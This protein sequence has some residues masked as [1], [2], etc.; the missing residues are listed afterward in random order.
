V[1]TQQPETPANHIDIDSDETQ[2]LIEQEFNKALGHHSPAATAVASPEVVDKPIEVP[3]EIKEA[4]A[5]VAEVTKVEG[6]PQVESATTTQVTKTDESKTVADSGLNVPDWAKSL[7]P[8][9]QKKIYDVAQAAQYHE[10]KWRSDVGRQNAL[11]QK[12]L[13]ARKQLATL[14]SQVMKPQDDNLAAAAQG[15]HAKSLAE[16]NQLIEAD[17]NLAKAIDLRIRAET[18]QLKAETQGQIK[19]TVDPLYQHTEQNHVEEQRRILHD[20]V[21]NYQEVIKSPVYQYWFNNHAA[22]GIQNLARSS[23]DASDAINILKMYAQEA[24]H[25]YNEMVNRGML[26]REEATV[27]QPARSVPAQDTALA[28][29]VAKTREEKVTQAP[30][31]TSVQTPVVATS[32]NS[33]SNSKPG[34]AIDL[35]DEY[36]KQ[37]FEAEYKKNTIRRI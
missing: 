4:P 33:L 10:Q 20:N 21:P 30:V 36:V 9:L 34:Q 6:T 24:P 22:P 19:A 11:Q 17:P 8:E 26:P 15:D 28:D 14:S 25:V 32:A 7:D 2:K 29:K 3:K 18:A 37:L 16:W 27:T 35:D 31:V 5:V 1:T 13:E 23:A 12:L